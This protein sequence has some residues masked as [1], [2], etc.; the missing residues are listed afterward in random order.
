[1]KL[2]TGDNDPVDDKLALEYIRT[3][4]YASFSSLKRVRDG[5]DGKV[6]SYPALDIGTE[7]HSRFLENTI[8]T[9]MDEEQEKMLAAMEK[10]LRSDRSV[11]MIMKDAVCEVEFKEKVYGFPTLGYI[12]ILPPKINIGD[13]KTTKCTTLKSFVDQMDFLQAALYLKAMNRKDFYYIGISKVK[14]YPVFTFRVSAYQ[15]RLDAAH[16]EL[17]TII[18]HVKKSLGA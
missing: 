4:G 2:R 8:L 12:D 6:Q 10:S 1:M 11:A 5:W 15:D 16:K 13:L 17:K 7:L 9:T 14:P 3:K 18:T